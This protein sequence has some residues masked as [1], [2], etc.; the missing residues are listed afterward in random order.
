MNKEQ[1]IDKDKTGDELL[2]E[3]VEIQ[4]EITFKQACFFDHFKRWVEKVHSLQSSQ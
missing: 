2:R 4:D 3:M 1:V